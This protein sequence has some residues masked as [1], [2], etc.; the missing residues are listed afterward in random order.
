MPADTDDD[1]DDNDDDNDDDDDDDDRNAAKEVASV[2]AA[3]LQP[4][5]AAAAAEDGGSEALG[6][7]SNLMAAM[8]STSASN[9]AS[10]SND[11]HN[12]TTNPAVTT[13]KAESLLG[14]ASVSMSSHCL[15]DQSIED[16]IST[17]PPQTVDMVEMAALAASMVSSDE[18]ERQ[19]QAV[20]DDVQQEVS[21]YS[22]TEL[23]ANSAPSSPA[24]K[25]TL[26]EAHSDG[27]SAAISVVESATSTP[28][29]SPG[30][31]LSHGSQTL[32]KSMNDI[33]VSGG[34]AI[35]SGN[36]RDKSKKDR[37]SLSQLLPLAL[38]HSA[39]VQSG[40]VAG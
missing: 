27:K 5:I 26:D 32:R 14:N 38:A 28:A 9:T 31:A 19:E 7:F 36:T 8:R 12:A 35:D 34:A 6:I 40:D 20:K 33:G 1:D 25:E 11:V 29:T 4:S 3:H 15:V 10:T 39:P 18:E 30:R 23:W 22:D 16:A 21:D 37:L 2:I 24:R 13:D 17:S